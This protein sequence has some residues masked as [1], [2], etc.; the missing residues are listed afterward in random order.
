MLTLP[1]VYLTLIGAFAPLFASGFGIE[2][3]CC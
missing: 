2:R 1:K 3:W